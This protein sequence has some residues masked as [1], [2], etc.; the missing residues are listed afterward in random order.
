MACHRR[1]FSRSDP[2][3]TQARGLY[4]WLLSSPERLRRHG[5]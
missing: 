1:V 2:P 3:Q 5:I 4:H